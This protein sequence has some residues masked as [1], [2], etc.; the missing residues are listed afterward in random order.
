MPTHGPDLSALSITQLAK[1]TGCAKETVRKRLDAK[2]VA[3]ARRDGRTIYYH[4]PTALPVILKA[5]DGLNPAAEKARLDATKADLAEL[6][7]AER[8]GELI[9]ASE[10]EAAIVVILTAVRTKL[11]ALPAA[12]AQEWAA[13]SEPA[14]C[15]EI[16]AEAV[17]EALEAL[18]EAEVDLPAS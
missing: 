8:R 15:E 17:R 2:G 4:P 13:S 10:A 1:L 5:G 18:S 12:R 9:S 3:P 6:D 16:A 7:L 11:L 14:E